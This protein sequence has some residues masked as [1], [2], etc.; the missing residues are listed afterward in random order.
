MEL[1][2]YWTDEFKEFYIELTDFAKRLVVLIS[3]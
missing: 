3:V 1:E 2:N